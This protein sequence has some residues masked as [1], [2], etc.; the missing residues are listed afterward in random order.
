VIVENPTNP[1]VLTTPSSSSIVVIAF[2]LFVSCTYL[3]LY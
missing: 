1:Y 2:M 3:L